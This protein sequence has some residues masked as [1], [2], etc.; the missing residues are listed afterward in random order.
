MVQSGGLIRIP[1]RYSVTDVTTGTPQRI[2]TFLAENTATRDSSGV[3][4]K[5]SFSSSPVQQGVTTDTTTW[6]VVI[7]K[8]A[9]TSVTP[10]C[11]DGWRRVADCHAASV[12]HG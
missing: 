12:Q 11:P 7:T 10:Q 1:V 2:L 5:K 3:R 6:G 9:D 4:A 8:P